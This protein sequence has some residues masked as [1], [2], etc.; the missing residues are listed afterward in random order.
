M[1]LHDALLAPW[2][3]Y[4][5]GP[6]IGLVVPMLLLIGNRSFGISSSFRHLC[7]AWLPAGLEYFRYEWRREAWNLALVAGIV[8]GGW[9][10]VHGLTAPGTA[11]RVSPAFARELA[12]YGI[13]PGQLMLPREL[14][15]WAQLATL[16]TLLATVVGGLLVGFGAR[17][18]NG[19]TGGHAI[20][21]LAT[22][23]RSSLVAV[24]GFMAGGFVTANL[25]VPWLL[26]RLR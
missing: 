18:A 7:A 4:V 26:E 20:T 5:T 23:Q 17:Y 9:L 11:S 25:V 21:G 2:P 6:L 16:P 10:A 1:S 13:E 8:I 19:C 12:A 3:W 24:L 14:F 15:A 22:L